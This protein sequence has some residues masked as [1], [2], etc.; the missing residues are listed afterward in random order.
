LFTGSTKIY[1]NDTINTIRSVLTKTEL[2]TVL[3]DGEFS[4]NVD[5]TFTQTIDM[6]SKQLVTFAKQPTSSDDPKYALYMPSSTVLTNYLYNA[7]VTFTKST[8][9]FSDPDSEGQDIT[10]F[11]QKFTIASST[12]ATNLVLFKSAE[13][14][15]LSSDDPSA[16][17]TINGKTYTVILDSASDTTATIKV[18]APDGTSETQKITAGTSKKINGVSVAVITSDETNLKLSATIVAGSDKYTFTDGSAVTRGEE[19]NPIDGTRVDFTGT[20]GDAITKIVVSVAAPDSD[21]DAILPGKEFVDPVFGTFKIDFAGLNIPDDSTTAREAITVTPNGEDKVNIKFTEHRGY[22]KDIRFVTNTTTGQAGMLLAI[23]DD[24]HN[25]TV[26]EMEP[27]FKDEYV[28]VGNEE[29]GYLMRV[30]TIT[31]SSASGAS[32]DKVS[33]QDVFTG[34]TTDATL[35]TEG[36]GTISIGGK[37]YT[38]KYYGTA[39]G[40]SS[41]RNITLDYPDSSGA[42]T[43]VIFPTIQT[44]KGALVQF[45]QPT[46]L[47]LGNWD[48]AGDALTTIKIPNGDGYTSVTAAIHYSA[49]DILNYTIG[50]SGDTQYSCNKTGDGVAAALTVGTVKYNFTWV[51]GNK[52]KVYLFDKVADANV[53][54]PAVVIYEA[55]DDNSVYES[56]IVKLNGGM[57][58]VNDVVRSWT[59]GSTAFRSTMASD[60]KKVQ[61]A[62]LYGSIVTIDQSDSD[63]YS[64]IISYPKEQLY[65]E[66]YAGEN[67]AEISAA[68]AGGGSIKEL[69]SVVV[70]DSD[71][72]SVQTKNLIV[73]GG[74]CVNAVAANILGGA[75]CGA[76]FEEATGVGAG[77]YLLKTYANPYASTKVA[78]LVAGYNA[79]DTVNAATA[80]MDLSKAVS[81]EVAAAA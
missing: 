30:Y 29:D 15:S 25:M 59:S 28:V 48:G 37:V 40:D 55:K 52:T 21:H 76:D 35:L 78:T 47:S 69:G 32:Y 71:V 42:N 38:V 22:E 80:L 53:A 6:G 36:S 23:D 51:T 67:S 31:N 11:G 17:V 68:T 66:L 8:L 77:Q 7:T 24:G 61:E 13:R 58:G 18:V 12:D 75:L 10:L 33:L 43:G 73:V 63:Q 4:G 41:V 57:A 44:S 46:T 50:L 64:A 56:L 3:K 14:L 72:A 2:P 54:Q 1:I 26:V 81:T 74:S 45:V 39:D 70:A 62:D 65:A 19:G 60:T 49:S 79:A 20:V 27:I 5:S 34:E 9:N 16:E